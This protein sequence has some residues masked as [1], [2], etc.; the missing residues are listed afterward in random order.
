MAGRDQTKGFPATWEHKVRPTASFPTQL[1]TEHAWYLEPSFQAHA[2]LETANDPEL[3]ST[4]DAEAK[5]R[6][7]PFTLF[8]SFRML[9]SHFR[10]AYRESS[11]SIPQL[12]GIQ[13]R[14]IGARAPARRFVAAETYSK[15]LR[16]V[17][18]PRTSRHN[19]EKQRADRLQMDWGISTCTT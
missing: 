19:S 18:L 9:V 7:N 16:P 12:G 4:N 14:Q 10:S 13:T 2:Q 3:A 6:H 17:L 1:V 5:P 11:V 8:V 15:D